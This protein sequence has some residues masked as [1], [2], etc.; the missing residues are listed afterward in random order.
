MR[1]CVRVQPV[2]VLLLGV[3]L[4][5]NCARLPSSGPSYRQIEAQAFAQ[6]ETP[7][8]SN[9]VLTNLSL[10]L[11]D[12]LNKAQ[13]AA[14]AAWTSPRI[15]PQ[16]TLGVGDLVDVTIF[17][18]Q[19][20]GLFIPEDAGS[21]PGNYITLPR[22]AVDA[23]G[24]IMVPYAGAVA[25][26]GRTI[27]AVQEDVEAKLS[28]RAIEPQV[29]ISLAESRSKRVSVLGVVRQPGQLDLNPSGERVLDLIA[30]AG[31]VDGPQ[32]E[33]WVRIESGRRQSAMRLTD[34]INNPDGNIFLRPGD[35]VS[36]SRD[37]RSYLVLGAASQQ[38]QFDFEEDAPSLGE[39]IARAGGLRDDRASAAQVFLYRDMA[40]EDLALAG[41]KAA[42]AQAASGAAIFHVDLS[43]PAMLFAAQRLVLRDKD[44]VYIANADAVEMQ[45][46]LAL[47]SGSTATGSSALADGAAIDRSLRRL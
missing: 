14:P 29:I 46:F 34:L 16:P 19:S 17:E 9:Y 47:V 18:S 45:K 35:I 41:L 42:P 21:R 5:A 31:G 15:A 32:Q 25:A 28:N 24:A 20:G 4:L 37:R 6:I 23:R 11:A 39:A 30:R 10:D 44:V 22:Q 33:A 40:R 12:R 43:D 1:P 13:V 7:A 26:D 27:S 38:G 8:Q 3:L 2:S 36:V